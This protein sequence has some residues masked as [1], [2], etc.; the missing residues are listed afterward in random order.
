GRG[1]E[2]LVFELVPLGLEPRDG[3][4]R[5]RLRSGGLLRSGGRGGLGGLADHALGALR[6]L[7]LGF[8]QFFFSRW[9]NGEDRSPLRARQGWGRH[10]TG[11]CPRGLG[12][13]TPPWSS[14]IS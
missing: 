10:E 9:M 6:G 8:G 14:V 7:V 2:E 5:G 4:V 1:P 13:S 11:E 3:I 12:W